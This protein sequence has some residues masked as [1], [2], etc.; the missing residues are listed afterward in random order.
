MIKRCPG[1]RRWELYADFPLIDSDGLHIL[2]DR[3]SG[4]DR[5]KMAEKFEDMLVLF[6]ELP[7]TSTEF[8]PSKKK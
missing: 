1:D 8:V 6:S 7:S 3:R 4:R 5:R 2:R